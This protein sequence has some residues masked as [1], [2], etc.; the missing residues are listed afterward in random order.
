MKV[1]IPQNPQ[2][3]YEECKKLFEETQ[4]EVEDYDDFD[5]IVNN[6]FFYSFIV[7]GKFRGYIYYYEIEGK[8][9]VNAV[10]Y[11][12]AMNINLE[13]FKESLTWWNCD[14]YARTKHKTAIYQILK[15]GFKKIGENLYC[16]KR[17]TY[18]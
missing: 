15:C 7:G 3:N 4:S 14:I 10:A 16:L 1:L 8:L 13:C 11:R 2:F 5:W 12:K 6:T 18:N 9:Y 17:Q